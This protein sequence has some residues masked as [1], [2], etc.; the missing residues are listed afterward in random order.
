[1]IVLHLQKISR[2]KE[3]GCSNRSVTGRAGALRRD[4]ALSEALSR[5]QERLQRGDN[6]PYASC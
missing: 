3:H 4:W 5:D 2:I 1:M 6:L